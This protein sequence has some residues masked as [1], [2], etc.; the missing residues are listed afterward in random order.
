MYPKYNSKQRQF[1]IETLEPRRVFAT[2]LTGTAALVPDTDAEVGTVVA[3]SGVTSLE[4][5]EKTPLVSSSDCSQDGTV[6]LK[7]GVVTICGTKYSDS[8]EVRYVTSVGGAVSSTPTPWIRV[9]LANAAGGDLKYFAASK[10]QHIEFFGKGRNDTF[11]NG[12]SIESIAYGGNGNDV[13]LGGNATDRFF[14]GDGDD[15]LRG[16]NGNDVLVGDSGND[17]LQGERGFDYLVGGTGDD[18]LY[19]GDQD[20]TLFGNEDNDL[21][22]GGSGNDILDGGDGGDTLYGRAGNDVMVGGT[23]RDRLKGGVGDDLLIGGSVNY[24][25]LDAALSAVWAEWTSGHSYFQRMQ[26]LLEI[27]SGVPA[28]NGSYVLTKGTTVTDD[29]AWDKLCGEEDRD[30]FFAEWGVDTDDHNNEVEVVIY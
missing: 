8:A 17:L 5:I 15:T 14:G 13:L 12:S 24:P 20:D 9:R 19:G 23:G 25:D 22:N 2:D 1:S 29:G 3:I 6:T 16:R 10:V 26:N 27:P 7:D 30:L 4:S 21:L 18:D 28:L 11:D